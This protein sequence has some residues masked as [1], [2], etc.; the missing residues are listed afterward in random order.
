MDI[1]HY[2]Y[3]V[4]E[5]PDSFGRGPTLNNIAGFSFW[6][7]VKLFFSQIDIFEYCC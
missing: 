1:G 2:D 7:A 6:Q 5:C 3:Y 4:I